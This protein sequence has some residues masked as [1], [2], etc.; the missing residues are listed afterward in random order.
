MKEVGKGRVANVL[1][2]PVK[3]HRLTATQGM[4]EENI[5]SESGNTDQCVDGIF[6]A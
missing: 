5:C 1:L 3:P 4:W 6:S 2:C